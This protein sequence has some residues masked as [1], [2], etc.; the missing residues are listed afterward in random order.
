MKL[1]VEDPTLDR[2]VSLSINSF[3]L[4]SLQQSTCKKNLEFVHFLTQ[5]HFLSDGRLF[6]D[7]G[8]EI[9]IYD[10]GTFIYLTSAYL[11]GR[12]IWGRFFGLGLIEPDFLALLL[13]IR[14]V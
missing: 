5:V 8:L 13:L 6:I 7:N 14:V 3:V 2:N 1:T 12:L 4:K 10:S 9:N 11:A